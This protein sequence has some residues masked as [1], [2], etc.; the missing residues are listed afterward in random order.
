V[1]ESIPSDSGFVVEWQLADEANSVI[2]LSLAE[3]QIRRSDLA[4][5]TPSST[6]S[7]AR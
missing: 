1:E 3:A 5:M 7:T 4:A 6:V 2:D